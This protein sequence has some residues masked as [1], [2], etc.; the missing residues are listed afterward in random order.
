[1]SNDAAYETITIMKSSQIGATEIINN[2]IG[3]DIA[4]DPGPILLVQPT[5]EIAEAWSKDRLA[6]MLRDTPC[7]KTKVSDVKSRNRNNTLLHK[8]Y[9]GGHITIGGANSPSGLASRP[10]RKVYFDEVDRYPQSAGTEGDP[11]SLGKKRTTTFWNRKI[12]QVSTPTIEG[13]SRIATAYQESDQ[14]HYY[15]PCPHCEKYHLLEWKYVVWENDDPET[16]AHVCPLCGCLE[17]DADLPA[18]L[19]MGEWRKHRPEVKNHA[20]FHINELYSPWVTFAE[21]AIDFLKAKNEPERLKTWINTALGETWKEGKD[22]GDAAKLMERRENYDADL[23]PYGGVVITSGVDVQDNRIELEVIAWGKDYENWSLDFK[24]FA[25]DPARPDVW[26][27]LDTYLHKTFAHESGYKLRILSTGI[28]TGGH[29]TKAAYEFC[30]ARFGQRVF[31]LKGAAGQGKP[32]TSRPSKNNLGKINLYT[33]G[34]ETAKDTIASYL[35]VKEAGPGYCHFPHTHDRAYFDQLLSER[36][37]IKHDRAGRRVRSWQLKK[38]GIRNEALDCRVYAMAALSIIGIDLN[39]TVKRFENQI[40]TGI[41]TTD[42][43]SNKNMGTG[44]RMR[45]AG[46]GR[47]YSRA[48]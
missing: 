3:Y 30:G 33:V 20:G 6:P 42:Q 47:D 39:E 40:K 4:C 31:A 29:H 26:N 2:F 27:A 23:V 37:K 28:D 34:T 41:T 16:A 45:S 44:R 36:P 5:K 46:Y 43:P 13:F 18:M 24:V 11:I 35:S 14:R 9:P 22:I 1:M 17:T 12:I 7:L 32:I 21:T 38:S 25:G 48:S 15:V 8:K 10:V 19:A